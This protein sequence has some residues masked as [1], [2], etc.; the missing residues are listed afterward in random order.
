M[1]RSL[2]K[3]PYRRRGVIAVL[4]ASLFIVMLAVVAFAVDIGYMGMVRTQLQTAADSAAL[5][6]AGSSSTSWDGMVTTAQTFAHYHQVGGKSIILNAGDVLNGTWD[7][8]THTFSALPSGQMGTAVKVTVHANDSTTGCVPVFFGRIL[9]ANPKAEQASAV[10]MVNPRDICFV[11]DLSNSMSNDSN[12]DQKGTTALIQAVYDDLFGVTSSGASRVTYNSNESTK[13]SSSGNITT[14]MNWLKTNYPY[15]APTPDTS[16]SASVAYWTAALNS[17]DSYHGSPFINTKSGTTVTSYKMSYKSYVTFL[18]YRGRNQ[19]MGAVDGTT[20]YSIMSVMNANYKSHTETVGGVTFDKFP[21]PEMPTHAAR[22]AIIAAIQVIQERN[23]LIGDSAYKDHVSIVTFDRKGADNV[24]IRQSLT[25]D[26]I[27]AMKSAVTL[28]ACNY[29]TACTDSDG[30]LI[31]AYNYI[32][33]TNDSGHGRNNA[34]KVIVF[35]TDGLPNLNETDP[36][37]IAKAKL[38][39]PTGWGTDNAQNGALYQ[40]LNMQ[41]KNWSLFAVGVGVQGSQSFM[42]L[43]AGMAGTQVTKTVNGKE[44]TGAY[45][46]AK[47]VNTYETTLRDIFNR[48]IT[49]PKLRLVQ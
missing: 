6:A 20:Y 19:A 21:P 24:V 35:L 38:S 46:I 26:Y 23:A 2:A 5:A 40:A 37:D 33:G 48:I 9:G 14:V 18:M 17:T 42:D 47:D 8:N 16:N 13:A 10:A 1:K 41:G 22:R 7:T 30:G 34:N 28:Q 39:H 36:S 15:I 32:K 3:L 25:D 29:G 45:D 43:M 49:N 12:P 27:T 44:T 11:V 4:T 31:C